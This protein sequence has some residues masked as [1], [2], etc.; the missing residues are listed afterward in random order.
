MLK[1]SYTPQSSR[2]ECIA[3]IGVP[4]STLRMSICDE[5]MLPSV[6]PPAKSDLLVKRCIGEPAICANAANTA[7]ESASVVYF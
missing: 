1:W 3:N 6:E 2:A 4:T 5:S 7:A